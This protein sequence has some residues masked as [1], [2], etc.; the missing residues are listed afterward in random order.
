MW[1]PGFFY[2][3]RI[4]QPQ[5]PILSYEVN[6]MGRKNLSGMRVQCNH[7]G[8]TWYTKSTE[9]VTSCP[10]CGWRVRI[11]PAKRQNVP[12]RRALTTD[13]PREPLI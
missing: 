10:K 13:R 6:D 7:C 1:L 2:I 9:S 5:A 11:R 8:Y 3:S 12:T 4:D